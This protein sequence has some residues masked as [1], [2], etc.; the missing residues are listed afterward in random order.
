MENNLR[1]NGIDVNQ[2]ICHCQAGYSHY[3][4]YRHRDIQ[5]VVEEARLRAIQVILEVDT[6]G[7]AHALGKVFPGK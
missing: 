7:H 1:T 4:V 6:P 2:C 5:A 3:H